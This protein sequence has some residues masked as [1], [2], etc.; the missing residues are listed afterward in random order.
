MDL[1]CGLIAKKAFDFVPHSRVIKALELAKVPRQL[2]DDIL[3]LK[4]FWNTEV[5]L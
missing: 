1:P 4:Q 5:T 3:S 2:L